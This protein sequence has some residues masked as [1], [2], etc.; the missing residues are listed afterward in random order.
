MDVF[1]RIIGL[2]HHHDVDFRLIGH[3]PEGNATLASA[4][5]GHCPS[6]A[7]KSMVV[8]IDQ[9]ESGCR[10]ALAVVP[11][12]RRVAL[13]RLAAL[14]GGGK[15]RF[16]E[17]GV[18]TALTGCVMGAVPPVSFDERLIAVVDR[19]L[20]EQ[21][22]IVISAGRLECSIQLETAAFLRLFPSQVDDIAT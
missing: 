19:G 1:E 4:L 5:R 21:P 12:D 8:E 22:E 20:C 16:A 2:L 17:P 7:A 13:K 9:A 3:Q 18:A 15:A 10:Y 11:G 6:L 14:M